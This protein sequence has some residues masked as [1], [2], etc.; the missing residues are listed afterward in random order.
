MDSTPSWQAHHCLIEEKQHPG[1]TIHRQ[2]AGA[3]VVYDA[4]KTILQVM[5]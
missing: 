1:G 2:Y 3:D 4:G 5:G